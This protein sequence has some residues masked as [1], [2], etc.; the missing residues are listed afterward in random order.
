MRELSPEE[1]R[2]LQNEKRFFSLMKTAV[3]PDWVLGV[4]QSSLREDVLGIDAVARIVR[5][6]GTSVRV[7][8][9]IKS[10]FMGM[11]QHFRKYPEDWFNRVLVVVVNDDRGDREI[12]TRILEEF[13]H[14]R[15]HRY[16]YEDIFKVISETHIP[17]AALTYVSEYREGS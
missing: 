8:I 1:V 5:V 16:D 2:G 6:D 15:T 10:S 17:L 13:R 4:D 3:F 14:V 7:P 12:T 11:E 9:Q